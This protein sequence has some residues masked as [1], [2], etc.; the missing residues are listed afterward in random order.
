MNYLFSRRCPGNKVL[1]GELAFAGAGVPVVLE[2]RVARG[3]GCVEPVG[4]VWRG[5]GT[6]ERDCLTLKQKGGYYGD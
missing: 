4:A 2:P 1:A 6:G 3:E 5:D